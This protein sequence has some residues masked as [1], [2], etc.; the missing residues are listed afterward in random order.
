MK[1]WRHAQFWRSVELL[2]RDFEQCEPDYANN[3]VFVTLAGTE[4]V[5]IPTTNRWRV[6]GEGAW[7]GWATP[8]RLLEVL[9]TYEADR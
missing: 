5:Y 7:Q 3:R 6:R 2:R 9:A 1:G 8:A 4:Y